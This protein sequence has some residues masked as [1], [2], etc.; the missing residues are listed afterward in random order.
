MKQI[1]LIA[2]LLLLSLFSCEKN[3]EFKGKQQAPLLVINSILSP[4]SLLTASASKSLFFLSDEENTAIENADIQVFVNGEQVGK[5]TFSHSDSAFID[6][7]TSIKGQSYYFLDY[8][9]KA[10]DRIRYEASAPGLLQGVECETVI[11]QPTEIISLETESVKNP[12]RGY[13]M[14]FKIKFQ[15][16]PNEKNYYRIAVYMRYR[17]WGYYY[18]GMN[19]ITL[20]LQVTSDDMVFDSN[21]P[22]SGFLTD[23]TD[24][25]YTTVFSDDLIDSKE[26][27]IKCHASVDG[28]SPEDVED[29]IVQFISLTED[30]YFYLRTLEA[31]SEQ[32]DTPFSE[33][34]QIY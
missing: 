12:N 10:G 5:Y 25:S 18:P 34:V 15:D 16:T 24:G 1:I 32:G 19:I 27:T 6:I 9:P 21:A 4:D 26:Y 7:L 11:P 8:K 31:S 20:P 28:F 14:D 23:E 2:T 13:G 29:I 33:P 30:Y 22:T 3:I 17:A